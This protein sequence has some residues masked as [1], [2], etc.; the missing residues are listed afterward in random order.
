MAGSDNVIINTRERPVSTDI[1]NLQALLSRTISELKRYMFASTQQTAKGVPPT[2]IVQDVVLGGLRVTPDGNNVSISGGALMQVDS[3]ISPT[4]GTFDSDYRIAI[5]TAATSFV[6][7]APGGETYYLLEAQMINNVTVSESRDILDAGSGNFVATLVDKVAQRQITFQLL[8]GTSQAPVP[9]GTPWVPIAVIRRPGGGGAV[10]NTDIYDVRPKWSDVF[11]QTS[12][13][14]PA[15]AG[16][17]IDGQIQTVTNFQ[18]SG[19]VTSANL[20]V[21]RARAKLPNGKIASFD[22]G[23]EVANQTPFDP[24][25]ALYLEPGT[26][27]AADFFYL[28]LCPWSGLTPYGQIGATGVSK[29][30]LV[31]STNSP[32]FGTRLNAAAITLPAP[33]GNGTVARNEAVCVGIVRSTGTVLVAMESHDGRNY[34]ISPLSGT[35]P[36]T[37]G[38]TASWTGNLTS[39]P[40]PVGP[41]SIKIKIGVQVVGYAQVGGVAADSQLVGFGAPGASLISGSFRT[42]FVPLFGI[43]LVEDNYPASNATT[44][45]VYGE[46]RALG[47]VDDDTVSVNIFG[48][49]RGWKY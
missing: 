38:P 44:I 7:P 24:F 45:A 9:S 2:D 1:N 16:S 42:D 36:G 26:V 22:N 49:V 32:N 46:T 17:F 20:Q 41:Q 25:D 12:N 29:G 3:S 40:F 21:F 35:S 13:G 4:P 5:N 14:L 18:A 6:M 34:L 23:D 11:E 48:T 43:E 37:L 33:W 30:I 10:V 19:A 15:Q 28:Y 39:M 8:T 27:N 47:S 31:L